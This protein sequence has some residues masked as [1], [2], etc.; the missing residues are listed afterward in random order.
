ADAAPRL[1]SACLPALAARGIRVPTYARNGAPGVVH[2]GLGAF[3]RAHQALVF[4][5]L[6]Q[7]GDMRWG[8]FGVAMRSS[9]VADSLQA[10]D[11]LYAVQLASSA[12][13]QWQVGGAIWQT[14]VAAREAAR[15]VQAIAAPSTRWLTLTVTEKGYGPELARLI[16]QGLAARHAAGLPG[17]TIASC[18]NLVGNGRQLQALCLAAARQHSPALTDWVTS[19]CAF[20][21]SMVDR[22]VPAT[23]PQRLAAA[24]EAL[25]VADEAALGSEAFWEWVIERRF[26]DASDGAV[27]AAAGV[28]VVDDVAPFEDAKLRLLNGSHTAMACMGAVA[29]WPVIGECITQPAVYRF[30]HGLMTHE[31]GPQLARPDWAS[32][33]DA[34]LVR[35]ANPAL[36]H[37]VHQIATDSSQKIPQRWPPSV[38]GA[39]HAGLPVERL[40]FAAAAWMRYV[41]GSDEQGKTYAMSDPMAG[42][43]QALALAHA[44]DAEASVQALSTLPAIWGEVLPQDAHWMALVAHRLDDIER[45]GVLA[46]LGRLQTRVD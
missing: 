8:V 10:Q 15:V 31:V 37:S 9:A 38:L 20:P 13:S 43:L 29:G 46:A 30:I 41:R 2:L 14:A 36:Q 17:L 45:L 6:L 39:L 23:A 25:G 27:L 28:T 5:A 22:I 4:D 16:A 44:G 19:H 11:G 35:F 12:G 40:A 24:R 7:R 32:Y 33:R 42:E 3:H 26:A 18:D 34:L 1:N 21:N